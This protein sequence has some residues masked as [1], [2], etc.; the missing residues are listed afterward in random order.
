MYPEARLWIKNN[1]AQGIRTH[2]DNIYKN[3][4]D[5]PSQR[6]FDLRAKLFLI[7]LV[8]CSSS[9]SSATYPLMSPVAPP[10]PPAA[11]T[12]AHFA[13]RLHNFSHC[14]ALCPSNRRQLGRASCV[15]K[16]R[17]QLAY[18]MMCQESIIGLPPSCHAIIILFTH[19]A[20]WQRNP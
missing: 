8:S 14:R 20:S 2:M 16:L 7:Y 11:A 18:Q 3:I 13:N 12:P 5:T 10:V 17:P 9:S 4:C 15:S 19:M 6:E 1:Q